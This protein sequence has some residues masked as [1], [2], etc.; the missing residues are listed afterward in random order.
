[1][2]LKRLVPV[3]IACVG[4]L[5]LTACGGKNKENS[6]TAVGSTAMQP[7]IQKAGSDYQAKHPET[8]I[9]VQGGGSGTGLSQAE[10]GAVN[11]GDSDIFAEQ[12]EGIHA[13][14]MVDHQVA[15]VGITPVVNDENGVSNLT[16]KQLFEIFTGKIKNW[17]EV[18]GKDLPI[19]V[20]N[21]AQGSGT[22]ATFEKFVLQGKEAVKSQEQDS[23]GTVKKIVQ[24]T[25]GTISYLSLPYLN[26]QIKSVSVDGIKATPANIET[27]K[28]KIWSY[29]HMYTSKNPSAKTK[30]FV[31]YLLSEKTQEELVKTAGYVSVHDMKVKTDAK[32][33]VTPK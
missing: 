23:N 17:K 8:N 1:M 3:G 4:L 31:N 30:A 2:K 16:S 5:M 27:N 26:K 21:R 24:N 12:K 14:K 6:V 19:I 18:G 29:E 9:T 10:T 7:L 22:R 11:I 15:V 25:P 13:D 32:G 28:W 20:I 33:I